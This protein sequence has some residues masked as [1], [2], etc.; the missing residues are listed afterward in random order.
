[1][2]RPWTELAAASI[3]GMHASAGFTVV[4]LLVASLILMAI[5]SAALSVARLAQDM[6]DVQ[7]EHSDVQQRIRVSADVLRRDL[8]M[9][10]AGTY[11]G[12]AV[13]PLNGVMAPVMPYR[14][15]GD[16]PD[17]RQGILFRPDVLS[18]AYVPA[19]A[20]QSTLASVLPADALD[21]QIA[22]APNCPPATATT[23]C[24]FEA[25][26]HLL[27]VDAVGHW[28]VFSVQEIAAGGLRVGHRGTAAA[29]Y[30]T[31]TAVSEARFVTYSLKLDAAS[32]VSQL[33]RHDG[34][35]TELPVVDN[36]VAMR[37]TYFGAAAPPRLIPDPLSASEAIP[38]YGPKPPLLSQIQDGWPPGENCLF[39]VSD[40]VQVPR[41]PALDA[42]MP[43]VELAPSLFTDGPWCP[44][45]TA[46]N[47][48]DADL[49]RVRSLRVT[50]RVQS[51]IASLRGPAS[52]L[53]LNGG[54]ARGG[55]RY[56][57]DLEVQVDVTP[58]NL[59]LPSWRG[60][61]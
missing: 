56:V 53:F 23:L 9:A 3:A 2:R 40:G 7:P 59:N 8:L 43:V 58:R 29:A 50:L 51:A 28:D 21:V 19:T 26:A 37:F 18:L 54:T 41:L 27:I 46:P 60:G 6:F 4:E 38:T 45:S 12:P 5:I 36:V 42:A 14:A 49:L 55:A 10:G 22:A 31:G 20:S 44:H 30:P 32:G 15:F 48:Y 52:A 34:W 61:P 1:M 25:G 16:P 13:G 57:P 47:P 39:Q 11:A 33:T 24:G 17:P 35:A